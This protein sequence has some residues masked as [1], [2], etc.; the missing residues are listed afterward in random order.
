[1]AGPLGNRE[2]IFIAGPYQASVCGRG[3]FNM[4]PGVI[5]GKKIT[6]K[7]TFDIDTRVGVGVSH[8]DGSSQDKR[9]LERVRVT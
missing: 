6:C 8:Y 3:K 9:I 4:I 2:M 1:M 7:V 5:G